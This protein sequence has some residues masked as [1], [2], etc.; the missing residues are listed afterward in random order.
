MPSWTIPAAETRPVVVTE[1]EAMFGPDIRFRG[2]YEI[3]ARGDYALTEGV[4]CAHQSVQR[5]ALANPGELVYRPE[6]GYGLRAALFRSPT[7]SLVEELRTRAETR[8]RA[9]PRVTRVRE[10]SLRQVE[11]DDG[12]HGL[13]LDL[14]VDAGGR[15]SRL[16]P[17]V[18]RPPTTSSGGG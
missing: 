2:D 15:D 13:E 4:E 9:N 5:E 6:W 3:T 16:P 1:Q 18:V 7:K 17:V 14:R 12:K 11:F 10:C 8:T